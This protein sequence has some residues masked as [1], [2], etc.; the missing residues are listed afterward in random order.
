MASHLRMPAG[1][2]LREMSGQEFGRWCAWLALQNE[3]PTSHAD[4]AL[5]EMFGV[6]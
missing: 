2:V 6:G 3:A 4:S 5:A 1:R